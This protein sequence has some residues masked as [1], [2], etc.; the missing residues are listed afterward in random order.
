M[1]ASQAG[2][3]CVRST[4]TH[5]SCVERISA[6]EADIFLLRERYDHDIRKITGM[7]SEKESIIKI[8]GEEINLL[9]TSNC[10]L[11]KDINRLKSFS[12][13]KRSPNNQNNSNNKALFSQ[14]TKEGRNYREVSSRNVNSA[15]SIGTSV[16]SVDSSNLASNPHNV[17]LLPSK[18]NNRVELIELD[19]NAEINKNNNLNHAN[20]STQKDNN[21]TQG[22]NSIQSEQICLHNS[23]S[24]ITPDAV[25]VNNSN[26]KNDCSQPKLDIKNSES[27]RTTIDSATTDI[28]DDS[29]SDSDGFIGVKCRRA[30]VKRFFL[31]GIADTVTTETILDYLQKRNIHPTQL[32]LFSSRCKGTKS[33]K[34]N[35]RASE[36]LAL[37]ENDFWPKFV[38][39]KPWLTKGKSDKQRQDKTNK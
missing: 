19:K 12:V 13:Q 7:I 37:T 15:E 17:Q 28:V 34:L 23:D 36:S 25:E 11:Q 31:S 1:N 24:V 30:N 14:K 20:N 3:V 32:R 18:C 21:S 29:T 33:A 22:D 16:A 4:L 27:I 35:V 8:Q 38:S 2:N 9:K 39:C 26:L 10:E 6:L 5:K